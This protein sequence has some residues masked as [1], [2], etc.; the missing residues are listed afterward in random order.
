MAGAAREAHFVILKLPLLVEADFLRFATLALDA[1][2][3]CGGNVFEAALNLSAA[4]ASMR[5]ARAEAGG[6]LEAQLTAWNLVLWL[7]F[8]AGRERLCPIAAIDTASL[9]ALSWRLRAASESRNADLLFQQNQAAARSVAAQAKLLESLEQT[10]Q[11]KRRALAE[12]TMQAE[13]DPLTGLYNRR[14][15]DARL[16]L[17]VERARTGVRTLSL[18][19]LDLDHFKAINDKEGHAAGDKCLQQVG[20]TLR[21]LVRSDEDSACRTGGDEF[22]LII[23]A[24]LEKAARVAEGIIKALTTVS[25]GVVGY[26]DGDTPEALAARADSAL[27]RAKAAGR[28]Q[29]VVA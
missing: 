16:A 11:D 17:A 12:V 18:L 15:Y 28:G 13:V 26:S 7:S 25:I 1:A 29:L 3:A 20:V 6:V 22:A 10:L 23:A 8:G 4:S 2:R 9:K 14:A 21:S 19:F 27:Y 5:Q 24:P